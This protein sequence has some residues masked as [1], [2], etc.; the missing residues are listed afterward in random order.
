MGG[1]INKMVIQ[2]ENT[3]DSAKGL[4]LSDRRDGLTGLRKTKGGIVI[5]N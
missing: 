2:A 1:S 4:L 5:P 3:L